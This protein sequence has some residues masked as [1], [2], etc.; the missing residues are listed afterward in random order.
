MPR[1]D[2]WSVLRAVRADPDF[3]D[4]PIIMTTALGERNLAF[5]LGATDCLQKPVDWG[6]L[7]AVMARF[8][9]TACDG[10]M[11]IVDDDADDRE[12]ISDVLAREGW[13]RSQAHDGRRALAAVA[14]ERPCQILID[15]MMPGMGGFTFLRELRAGPGG[16]GIPAVVLTAKHVT[17]DDLRR[18]AG[19]AE[20]VLSE[21]GLR[22]QDLAAAARPFMSV[23]PPRR[24]LDDALQPEKARRNSS[25]P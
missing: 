16:P 10:P 19:R 4:T 14:R 7:Q 20:R 18:L 9:P 23:A 6:E 2:G 25:T 8:R 3:R 1:L 11:L 15:L 22:L 24:E 17:A 13:R 5:S 21:G 12:R